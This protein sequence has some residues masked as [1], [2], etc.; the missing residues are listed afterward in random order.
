MSSSRIVRLTVLVAAGLLSGEALARGPSPYLPLNL[1]PEIEREIDRVLLLAGR[2]VVRR[3]I[4][5][6]VVLDALPAA[7]RLDAVLCERVRTY[8]RAYTDRYGVTHASVEGGSTRDSNKTLPN[9]RGM[10]AEDEWAA[11][12]AGQ[13]RVHD[14]VQLQLGGVAY[15]GETMPSGSW[16]SVGSQYLQVDVGFREHWWSPMSDSAMLIGTQAPTMPSVTVS[17]YKPLTGLNV[18]YEA[19][20]ARMSH[21]D[22]LPFQDRTTSGKPRLA[23]LNVSIEPLPG[24]SLGASRLLQYGGGER[25]DSFSDLLNAFLRPTR[26]DNI[27]EDLTVADQFG[28]QVAA[29]TSKFL[30][31][32]RRPFSIYFEYAG[33][34]GSRSEGWRLGNVSLSAGIDIPRFWNRFDL[35]YEV[36]DWQNLWYVSGVYPDGTSNDGHVIGHWGADDRIARD[37]V[38]AQSH[39]LRIGWAAPFGGL[40]DLRYRTLQNEDYGLG[41]YQREHDVSLRYSRSVSDFVYGAEVNVG[42]DVFGEDFNRLV[43]FVRYS[44]GARNE[45][46]GAMEPLPEQAT[47]HVDIFV[48]AGVNATRVEFDPSD[49]VTPIDKNSAVGAHV[50]VG[51]RRAV[52]SRSDFG[53]RVEMDDFDGMTALGVRAIDYRYNLTRRFSVGAFAGAMRLDA[54]TAAYGYY[55]G[56]NAQLRDVLP[57]FDLNLD[58][59][60]S[61]KIA[62]DV[63]LTSDPASTWGD[64]IYQIES[65]SLYLS[66]RF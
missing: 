29:V 59:R 35:T 7:C 21:V 28:N 4:A 43:A 25:S 14:F 15:P 64:V 46:A 48:D 38:G 34:D 42:R 11:S 10:A 26:Y 40:F 2:P 50:G 33:E 9:R 61:D 12:V 13:F 20:M 17:N 45:F 16:L 32:A 22:G 52:T 8:L 23:G 66:Y 37:A 39:M 6:A 60:A 53:V 44:P 41:D 27:S 51:V 65:A 58:L 54:E 18:T 3:P 1:S 49:R 47:R 36:S 62:R 19:F 63:L 31:P 24:W 57:R 56:V 5:A 55:G 30:V